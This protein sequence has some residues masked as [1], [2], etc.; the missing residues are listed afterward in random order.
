MKNIKYPPY[1]VP[2]AT[3]LVCRKGKLLLIKRK[4]EPGAGKWSLPGGKVEMGEKAAATAAREIMEECGVEIKV[5]KLLD[6]FDTILYDRNG[7]VLYHYLIM[8]Y[9][10]EYVSGT[11]QNSPETL[12]VRWVPLDEASNYDLTDNAQ[13]AIATFARMT[14]RPDT[15]T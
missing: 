1:P 15:V 9:M 8:A 3:A 11:P 13:K 10:A 6:L 14:D 7:R 5:L 2:A 12:D 4:F